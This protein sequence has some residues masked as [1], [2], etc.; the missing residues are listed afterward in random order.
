LTSEQRE[1][2]HERVRRETTVAGRGG[3]GGAGG[4]RGGVGGG[5]GHNTVRTPVAGTQLGKMAAAG[6]K[7]AREGSWAGLA[8]WTPAGGSLS[9]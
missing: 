6:R 1:L 9:P 8:P 2:D 7:V 3:G 5:G 4:A